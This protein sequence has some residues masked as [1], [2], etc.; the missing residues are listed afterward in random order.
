MSTVSFSQYIGIDYSGAGR[1]DQGQAN[2][3]CCCL[4]RMVDGCENARPPA[5]RNWSRQAVSEWITDRLA[6]AEG[7]VIIGLDHGFSFP[8]SYLQQQDID[9]WDDLLEHIFRLH[10]ESKRPSLHGSGQLV[11]PSYPLRLAEMW[12]VS[13]KSVLWYGGKGQV[14]PATRAGIAQ[15]Y[16]LRQGLNRQGIRTHFWPFDGWTIPSGCH[17]ICEA[18]PAIYKRRYEQ[19]APSEFSKDTNP[20][21]FDAYCVARWLHERDA[22]GLLD[23]Y[24][25]PPLTTSE[26]VQ[27]RLEGW[28]LGVS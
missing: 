21:L 5:S 18:Y 19:V 25:S 4:N 12:T 27:A 17:V 20:D 15:L 11:G 13:A 7:P 8:L 2:I 24:F 28:I 6:T 26:Q 22:V 14:G 10:N 23:H 9:C 1:D 16:R 3:Q